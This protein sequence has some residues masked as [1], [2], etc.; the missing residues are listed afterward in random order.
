MRP[1]RPT[2]TIDDVADEEEAIADS[3]EDQGIGGDDIDF[4]RA[5]ATERRRLAEIIRSE[6]E[7]EKKET[8]EW[9]KSIILKKK[10]RALKN[11]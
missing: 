6:E 7:K 8:E 2:Q 5:D 3:Y 10:K 1:I 4:L 11:S 9:R